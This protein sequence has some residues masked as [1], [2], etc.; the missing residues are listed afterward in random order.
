MWYVDWCGSIL[1]RLEGKKTS[2]VPSSYLLGDC[3]S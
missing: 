3:V 2:F 1:D